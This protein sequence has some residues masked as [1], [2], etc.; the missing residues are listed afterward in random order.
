MSLTTVTDSQFISLEFGIKGSP[1]EVAQLL[2]IKVPRESVLIIVLISWLFLQCHY[3]VLGITFS[4][5]FEM[6]GDWRVS[7][8]DVK[9]ANYVF[10]KY[11]LPLYFPTCLFVSTGYCH[12]S[13]L[14]SGGPASVWISPRHEEVRVLTII[15]NL[16]SVEECY[17]EML[18]N[19]WARLKMYKSQS[20][21]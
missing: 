1:K 6:V 11:M 13:L 5:W 21:V 12:S 20:T 19:A 16:Q 2:M 14:C 9:C 4:I 7:T 18:T 8:G 10:H 17:T 15:L 3:Q